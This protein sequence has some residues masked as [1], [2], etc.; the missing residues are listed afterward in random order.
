MTEG[1]CNEPVMIGKYLVDGQPVTRVTQGQRFTVEDEYGREL[2]ERGMMTPIECPK[3]QYEIRVFGPEPTKKTFE[4]KEGNG[5]TPE[6]PFRHGDLPHEKPAPVAAAGDQ[7]IPS[8]DVP[9]RGTVDLGVRRRR[10]N[11]RL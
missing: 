3:V 6:E 9:Q 11:S 8:T 7:A 2:I 10:P 1:T 4:T 5:P